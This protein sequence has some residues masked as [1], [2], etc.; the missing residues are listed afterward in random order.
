MKKKF[1]KNEGKTK[2]IKSLEENI[3]DKIFNIGFGNNTF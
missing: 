1:K 3:W 2:I